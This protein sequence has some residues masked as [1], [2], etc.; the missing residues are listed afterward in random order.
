MG[1]KKILSTAMAAVMCLSFAACSSNTAVNDETKNSASAKAKQTSSSV[2]VLALENKLNETGKWEFDIEETKKGFEIVGKETHDDAAEFKGKADDNKKVYS[3][4][5]TYKNVVAEKLGDSDKL[6]DMFA[7]FSSD[8]S[9]VPQNEIWSIQCF[10]DYVGI[11]TLCSGNSDVTLGSMM[12]YM[13]SGT[14]FEA[15][16]WKVSVKLNCSAGT[17]TVD[18]EY[19]G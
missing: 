9:T 19:K 7:S 12:E 2:S 16:G 15:N 5:L 10:L 4:V 14:K 1:M 13:T 3:A 6:E 18:A 17:C 11:C 8:P